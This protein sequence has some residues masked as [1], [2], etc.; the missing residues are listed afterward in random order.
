MA[1]MV[2]AAVEID[3]FLRPQRPHDGY[4]FLRA[5]ATV[6]EI[7]AQSLIFYSVPANTHPQPQAPTAQHV[8]LCG[9]LGHQRRLPLAQNDN[10]GDQFEALRARGQIAVEYKWL[11]KH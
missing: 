4:L 6:A 11:M 7:L 2:P 10:R 8:N 1:D 3:N 5:L 9:L